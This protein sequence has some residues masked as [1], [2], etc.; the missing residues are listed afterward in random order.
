MRQYPFVGESW[1]GRFNEMARNYTKS[2][3]SF[4]KSHSSETAQTKI[5]LWYLVVA[6]T[7]FAT[8][9]EI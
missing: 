1:L 7:V 2:D 4:M 6:R 5:S 9:G 8:C 3:I